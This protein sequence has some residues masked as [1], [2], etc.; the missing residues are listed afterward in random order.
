VLTKL[1]SGQVQ[2][3]EPVRAAAV[4]VRD[5]TLDAGQCDAVAKALATPDVCLVQGL[6][7]TGK[8][9]V[10]AE[11]LAQV[12]RRGERV[13]L[14]AQSPMAIDR[15]LE[16]LQPHEEIYALRLLAPEEKPE[17]LA[18]TIRKLTLPERLQ[19]LSSQALREGR[20]A[21]TARDQHCRRLRQEEPLWHRL[22]EMADRL[23]QLHR[24][25]EALCQ[26]RPLLRA[27]V[28]R[29]AQAVV[30]GHEAT[31]PFQVGLAARFRQYQ[32]IQTRV[33]KALVE[34]RE[35]I[36]QHQQEQPQLQTRIN[37]LHPLA[38]AQREKRWW[39][40]AW[41]RAL[42]RKGLAEALTSLEDQLNQERTVL[43]GLERELQRLNQERD[44]AS[45]TF[46]AERTQRTEKEVARRQTELD[47]QRAAFDQERKLLQ[48]KWQDTW[49][50]L[51]G[52]GP[53]PANPTPT[54]FR[55]A[56]TAWGQQVQ[57]EER[58]CTLLQQWLACLQETHPWPG[59]VR[60]Y[61]NVVAAT[62]A[63]LTADEHFRHASG[64]GP[65]FDLL[66]LQEADQMTE[67]EFVALARDARRC[68]L[69]AAP[70]PDRNRASGL[71]KVRSQ[72]LRAM[73]F[74]SLWQHLHWEPR[75]LPYAWVQE[76]ERLCCQLHPVAPDQRPWIETE[77]VADF[78]DIELRILALPRSQPLLAEVVF[79]PTLS[80][81]EAKTYIYQ[82][83][84]ELAVETPGQSVGWVEEPGRLVF[85]LADETVPHA[86]RVP[87]EPGVC[88][89]VGTAAAEGNDNSRTG[90]VAHWQTCCL[91][92][93]RAA[94]WDRPRAEEWVQQHLGVRD[95]GRTARLNVPHR[96]HPHLAAVLSHL[97]FGGDYQTETTAV[98]DHERGLPRAVFVPVPPIRE[99]NEL[100]K[101]KDGQAAPGRGGPLTLPRKG[102]AGLE[103]DLADPRHR[104]RLP[105]DLGVDLPNR[106]FVNYL[107][108]QAVVRTLE[109]MVAK[110]ADWPGLEGTAGNPD[111]PMVAVLALYPAQVDLI[112]GLVRQSPGLTT[113]AFTLVVDGPA[114][115]REREVAMV[116]LSL[117][118]SH[119]HRPITYGEGPDLLTLAL[120]RARSQVVLFGDPGSLARRSQWE[121]PL[122][123]LDEATAAREREVIAQLVQY[124][125]GQGPYSQA[126]H[127]REGVGT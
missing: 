40:A 6:P 37:A 117:T 45:Q 55:E 34:V 31:Q 30:E 80:I 66:V 1:L 72:P 88:E 25:T 21:W 22:Q 124:L 64:A 108:A 98:R 53:R 14:L 90:A 5:S 28:D 115:L 79:P 3:L 23:D 85:R 126:F 59:R 29:E 73:F 2:D 41:W 63:A 87:L 99:R 11:I 116:L 89:L 26:R 91:E 33:D 38:D 12:V 7:G 109:A 32:E 27:D 15:I 9:R 56:H 100:A 68:V 17:T 36:D 74:D 122:D 106:G 123:H 44:Q 97:L 16:L 65:N 67:S 125:Q 61:A 35:K 62:T 84:G 107:E 47:Y 4:G 110:P 46:Q 112:R 49:S 60:T 57:R 127:L 18:A 50:K 101:G 82:E 111:R 92:F 113:T 8:S 19:E 83:V 93:D 48:A 104:T 77:S 102:G 118:R 24:Q 51:D 94:G 75:N 54:A 86:V 69:I 71:R 43:E 103:I 13:L 96:M 42:F 20:K 58:E 105:S 121:G 81:Q 95:L 52:E 120:T 76:G 119:T 70:A 78:P 114:A 10:V 39:T